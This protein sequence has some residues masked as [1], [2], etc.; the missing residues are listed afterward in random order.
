[1]DRKD[2]CSYAIVLNTGEHCLLPDSLPGGATPRYV[3]YLV[4]EDPYATR[5]PY[6]VRV[7]LDQRWRLM[8]LISLPTMIREVVRGVVE[9]FG[10]MSDVDAL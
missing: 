8:S 3:Q 10:G 2:A 5:R 9:G 7:G 1:M 4:Q 6:H